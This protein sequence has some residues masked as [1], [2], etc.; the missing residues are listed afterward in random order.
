LELVRDFGV[1]DVMDLATY[2]SVKCPSK[3]STNAGRCE[4]E[5]EQ[6]DGN[7]DHARE[8]DIHGLRKEE[9]L[10]LPSV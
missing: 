6:K 4:A 1:D 10:S 8:D 7:L 5:I 3:G 9:D 2:Y